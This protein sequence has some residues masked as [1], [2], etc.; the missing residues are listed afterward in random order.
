ML[1]GLRRESASRCD[2][3]L[4][5]LR[6]EVHHRFDDCWC[7]LDAE[8]V[9]R[10]ECWS[11]AT[12]VRQPRRVRGRTRRGVHDAADLRTDDV[13]VIPEECDR[14]FR[15]PFLIHICQLETLPLSMYTT[16]AFPLRMG[17]LVV[18]KFFISAR[19]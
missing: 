14:Q 19:L 9:T 4:V 5:G 11:T 17:A 3:V 1:V 8:C 7:G 6:R 15:R 13:P 16:A 12:G 2:E 10:D 18:R